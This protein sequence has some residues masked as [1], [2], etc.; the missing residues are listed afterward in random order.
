MVQAVAYALNVPMDMVHVKH[1]NSLT[2]AGNVVTGGTQGS[3][4]CVYVSCYNI[5]FGIPVIYI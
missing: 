2:S 4:G 3:D 5:G 1:T